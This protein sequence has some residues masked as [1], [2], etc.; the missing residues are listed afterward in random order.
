MGQR[1]AGGRGE[2]TQRSE[3]TSSVARLRRWVQ[4][5]S[6][7]RQHQERGFDSGAGGPPFLSGG[8]SSP[9]SPDGASATAVLISPPAHVR[10][11]QQLKRRVVF[12]RGVLRKSGNR[13]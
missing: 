7:E 5:S 6:S 3:Q 11:E 9:S 8:V 10:A 2:H 13:K 4:L 1:G 12:L